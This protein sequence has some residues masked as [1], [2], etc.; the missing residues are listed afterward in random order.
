MS[1][2]SLD[3]FNYHHTLEETPGI[4][5]VCFTSPACG[6]C[7]AFRVALEHFIARWTDVAVFEIDAQMNPAL[8]NELGF[9]HLPALYLYNNGQFH[10]ELQPQASV[11]SIREAIDTALQHPATEAP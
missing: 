3:Q 5:L 2:P 7:K 9:F 6:S 10:R 4:A 8:V 1:L 11:E